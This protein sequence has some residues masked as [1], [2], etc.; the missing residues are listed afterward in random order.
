MKMNFKT[1]IGTIEV[2]VAEPLKCEDTDKSVTLIF[3]SNKHLQNLINT[4]LKFVEII[5]NVSVEEN[6]GGNLTLYRKC[7]GSTDIEKC[8]FTLSFIS[9]LVPNNTSSGRQINDIIFKGLRIANPD[10][11]IFI[12]I[13]DYVLQIISEMLNQLPDAE[14]NDSDVYIRWWKNI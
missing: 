3:E 6:F 4:G 11:N 14:Y 1:P 10:E 5:K 7:I 12:D 13:Q 2:G 9:Y 8:D